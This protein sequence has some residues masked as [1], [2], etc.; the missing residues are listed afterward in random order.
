MTTSVRVNTTTYATTHVAANMIRSL[1]QIIRASGLDLVH[2]VDQWEV[3]EAGVTTWLQSKHLT[4]LVLEVFDPRERSATSLVGRFDFTI[5]Y[6]YGADSDG[7]L[8]LDPDMIDYV[9]RKNGVYPAQCRYTF[10]ASTKPGRPAVPGWDGTQ[11]RS[12]DHL[13]RRTA[14][15]A[16][17]G[18]VIGAALSYYTRTSK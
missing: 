10:I 18:G 3:L 12:T 7:D 17:T 16:I 13:T 11:F 6:D 14:G 8:W 5:D 1:K 4:G 9:V 15:T 2:L